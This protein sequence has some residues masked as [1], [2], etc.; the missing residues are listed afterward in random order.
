MDW[1]RA[2][3]WLFIRGCR[4]RGGIRSRIR[5]RRG[6]GDLAVFK[7]KDLSRIMHVA[8]LCRKRS[9]KKDKPLFLRCKLRPPLGHWG[10]RRKDETCC[11]GVTTLFGLVRHSQQFLLGSC[12]PSAMQADGP[13]TAAEG[14][15]KLAGAWAGCSADRWLEPPQA[16]KLGSENEDGHREQGGQ[17]AK[18]KSGWRC[19]VRP[20]GS[21]RGTP[22]DRAGTPE[23]LRRGTAY[24]APEGIPLQP[25]AEAE[26]RQ[27]KAL[28]KLLCHGL[29]HA[30][31]ICLTPRCHRCGP[32]SDIPRYELYAISHGYALHF[33]YEHCR[34]V[35]SSGPIRAFNPCALCC[36]VEKDLQKGLELGM[37]P[38]RQ[39]T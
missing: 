5:R 38:A 8:L 34:D 31:E 11:F 33:D 29:R 14:G 30:R 24:K 1:G 36:T 4:R 16:G 15:R 39:V 3:E 17:A 2:H 19:H 18:L 35:G 23:V 20:A 32:Q 7:L 37:W 28:V 26:E 6:T 12:V 22:P 21:R 13:L 25:P 10:R 27:R 9:C